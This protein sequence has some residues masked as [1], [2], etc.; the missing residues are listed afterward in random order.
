M[1]FE[2]LIII[3]VFCERSQGFE[4]LSK[5]INTPEKN[6]SFLIEK[7]ISHLSNLDGIHVYY[8]GKYPYLN[9][10]V[11]LLSY[12]F[13]AITIFNN[14]TEIEDFD[15]KTK[16]VLIFDI[17]NGSF[18]SEF[19]I[20]YFVITFHPED[21]VLIYVDLLNN[22][23]VGN[24]CEIYVNNLPKND[25]FFWQLFR[26]GFFC[27]SLNEYEIWIMEP[28]SLQPKRIP[29]WKAAHFNRRPNLHQAPM[30][31]RMK[32]MSVLMK[33]EPFTGKM[34]PI[35]Q[36]ILKI[37]NATL[38][39]T[40]QILPFKMIVEPFLNPPIK[41]Y[42][43]YSVKT[44]CFVVHK[45]NFFPEWQALFRCFHW[46]IWLYIFLVWIVNSLFWH[47]V[48]K[49]SSL[50]GSFIDMLGIY[51]T[52]PINWTNSLEKNKSRILTGVILFVSLILITGL[53][54]SQ[55]YTN[56]QTPGCYPPIDTIDGIDKSNLTILC[57]Y[58]PICLIYFGYW[59]SDVSDVLLKL[60]DQWKVPR[61]ENNQLDYSV[62]YSLNDLYANS[63][64][65]LLYS[66]EDAIKSLNSI[67]SYRNNLHIVKEVI[68]TSPLFFQGGYMQ[69]PFIRYTQNVIYIFY[70]SGIAQWEDQMYEWKKLIR[71]LFKE[72]ASESF[73]IFSMKDLQIAFIILIFGNLM[74]IGIFIVETKQNT[75]AF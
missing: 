5:L 14:N 71:I 10:G 3:I 28:W 70:E 15:K 32:V 4:V 68:S 62:S 25:N 16:N 1:I 40:S 52:Y 27:E 35:H 72:E 7:G 64:I 74:A 36:H 58:I 6:F 30:S 12:H 22:K 56:L 41:S 49:S 59:K 67:Q 48:F 34:I 37:M 29:N 9:E 23:R 45:M 17:Y 54:Q 44:M 60:K 11:K 63:N 24:F 47:F 18:F 51:F 57:Q 39:L 66:C 53:L 26:M 31:F 73:K 50:H 21:N 19:N 61:D 55:L 69:T 43:V 13:N 20:D 33:N 42:S 75:H 2:I 46:T 65:A 8:Y 38:N